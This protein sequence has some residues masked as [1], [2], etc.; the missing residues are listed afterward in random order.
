MLKLGADFLDIATTDTPESHR[1]HTEL[2]ASLPL[3]LL[4]H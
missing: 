1:C 3:P 4:L 2:A